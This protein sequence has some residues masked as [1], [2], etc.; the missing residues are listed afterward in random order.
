MITECNVMPNV[1]E[2][3]SLSHLM[4]AIS[5]AF[6]RR[7]TVGLALIDQSGA[8]ARTSHDIARRFHDGG[9]LIALGNEGSSTDA[10][11]IAREFTNPVIVDKPA[12]PAMVL[13]TEEGQS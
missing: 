5:A 7:R 9:K 12:L 3:P 11:L 2:A 4:L 13:T 8:I 10:Q 6:E 1:I